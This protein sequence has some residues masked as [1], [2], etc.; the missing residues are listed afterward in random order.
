MI[1]TTP[2]LSLDSTGRYVGVD[3]ERNIVRGIVVCETGVFRTE[4]GRFTLES[5]RTALAL[6]RDAGP[7]GVRCRFRHPNA[8]TGADALGSFLGRMKNFR[9]DGERLRGDLYLD[10]TSLRPAPGSAGTSFGEY[11]MDLASSDPSALAASR[12]WPLIRPSSAIETAGRPLKDA[13]GELPPV[14]S[15]VRIDAVDVVDQGTQ[16]GRCCRPMRR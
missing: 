13:N 12:R 2:P 11:V 1:A 16:P 5:L 14:W 9:L 10:G 3:R 6:L 15:P 4:R 7:A 8:A